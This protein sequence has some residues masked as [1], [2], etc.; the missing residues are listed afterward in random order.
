MKKYFL[1]LLFGG[2][3]SLSSFAQLSQQSR[4]S[5]NRLSSEDHQL[6]MKRLGITS[7][8]PDLREN[9]QLQMQPMQTKARLLLT[10]ASR[11]RSCLKTGNP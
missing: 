2:M 4:D 8:D 5:I 11:I 6:M 10:S 9:L 3:I 7:L 1:I